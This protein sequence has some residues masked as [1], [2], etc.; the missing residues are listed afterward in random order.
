LVESIGYP[1]IIGHLTLTSICQILIFTGKPLHALTYAKEAYI[2]AEHLGDIFGQAGSLYLQARCHATFANYYHAQFLLQQSRDMLTACGQQESQVKINILNNHAEIYLLKSEY[3]ESR[4]LQVTVASSCQP[5]S[6]SAIIA[7]FNIAL[8]DI[9]TGADSKII[10]QNLDVA[11]SQS[12]GLYGYARR[13]ACL[14]A[15]LAAAELWLRDG[16]LQ[17]AI[18]MFEKCFVLSL[19]FSKELALLCLERLGDF[20]TGMSDISTTLRWGGVFLSLALKCKD[21]RQ[22]MQ[23]LRCL[24]QISSAQGDNKTALALFNVALDGFTFMDVHHWRA[25]CMVRI[26]DI[27]NGRGEVMNAVGLWKD[28]RPL[29]KRSSQMKDITRIDAKLAEIDPAVLAEYEEQLQR[30]SELNLPG[31]LLEETSSGDDEE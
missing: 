23:A 24:G 15:D 5:N 19:D 27:L 16:V 4:T 29:F 25:D 11:Q 1:T 12:K 2:Y 26:A 22:A 18:G 14:T 31:S 6:Y 7:N 9:A 13:H 21:K 3:L 30:L 8:I 20:S 17:T 10:C 28:A